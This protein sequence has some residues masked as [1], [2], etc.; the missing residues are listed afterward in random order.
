MNPYADLKEYWICFRTDHGKE[1]KARELLQKEHMLQ[2]YVPE[3]VT[4]IRT[5]RKCRTERSPL[6]PSYGFFWFIEGEIDIH[7]I[8]K[9]VRVINYSGEPAKIRDEV[10]MGIRN[11]EKNGIRMTKSEY[12]KGDKIRLGSGIFA[13]YEG[14]IQKLT[15]S[16]K[17]VIRILNGGKDVEVYLDDIKPIDT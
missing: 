10:I 15:K 6:F 11:K 9:N 16:E 13:G 14:E 2:V 12:E 5:K 8:K 1:F 7:P 4:D 3:K 17:A